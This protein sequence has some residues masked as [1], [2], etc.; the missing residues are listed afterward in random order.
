[1]T[2]LEEGFEDGGFPPT[3]WTTQTAGLGLPHA[4]HRTG[5]PL[6]VGSGTRSAI[7]GSGSAGAIE[8]WLISPVVAVAAPDDAIKFSWSGSKLW[9]GAVN[10]T[11]NIRESGTMTWTQV[12]SLG[13]DEPDSDAFIYRD[14]IVDLSGWSGMNVEFG[15]RVAGTNGASFAI[16]DVAVGDFTPTATP[17]NDVCGSATSL[18]S[19]F[20]VSGVTCYAAND[21]DPW[22]GPSSSCVGDQLDGPD[23]FYEITAAWGDTLK[24]SVTSDWGA[25]IYLVDNCQTPVCIAGGY[26]EDGR[27]KAAIYHR[28]APGGTYF[29]VVDGVTGSCGPYQL[30]GEIVP[31]PTGV[32]DDGSVPALRLLARPNPAGG[33]ITF[34]GTFP[35]TRNSGT[36]VEIYNVEG[37]RVRRVTG[38][39]D[40][41]EF[42]FTWDHRDDGGT[43]VASGLYFARL[44]VGSDSVVEKFVILR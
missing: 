19:T 6:D 20:D 8:E 21:L 18:G 13:A 44:R 42:S 39:A 2:S 10:A 38:R 30:V 15:F 28:F 24:A 22:T 32:G 29:L 12:W 11:L 25:G 33:P 37:K 40:S 43:P 17:V 16:D 4:W 5:D 23:V 31:S 14:R 3:G 35:P 27:T 41:G 1:L 36:S 9:S 34:V 7:V 26:A